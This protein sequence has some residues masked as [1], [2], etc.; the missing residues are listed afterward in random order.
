[1]KELDGKVIETQEG[2][3]LTLH[4]KTSVMD[5]LEQRAG[6]LSECHLR[7]GDGWVTLFKASL[8]EQLKKERKLKR[9]GVLLTNLKQV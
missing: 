6:P 8:A 7:S 5:Y 9:A 4:S 2:G 3:G 1:M